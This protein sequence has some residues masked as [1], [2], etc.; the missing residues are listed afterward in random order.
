MS[1]PSLQELKTLRIEPLPPYITSEHL[2]QEEFRLVAQVRHAAIDRR[3]QPLVGYVEFA[4]ADIAARVLNLM[5]VRSYNIIWAP[6]NL[7]YQQTGL[8][9]A[10][11]TL[12]H[13]GSPTDAP[14]VCRPQQ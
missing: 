6:V 8:I 14:V 2:L 12:R 5:N 13:R 9:G 11:F 1:S 7:L 3:Q 4:R 10:R